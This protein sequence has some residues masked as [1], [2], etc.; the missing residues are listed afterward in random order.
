[1]S[2]QTNPIISFKNFSFQYRAQKKPTL[3]DINLDIYPGER[4]LIAGPSGS[5]KSTLAACINGLN[6]FSNP[7]EC[8]G[9]LTVDGVDAPNS[10]IF[11]LS[12][13]VGTVLQDPDGQFIG[14]TVGEDIAF[15]LE[16][17]CVPQKEMHEITRHAAELVGIENRL[18]HAPHELSGG[19]KQRVSL[20]GVMVD[21]VKILM[22]DEP[23]ASLDPATGKQAIELIDEIQHKTDTTVL[24]IEHRLED[25][26]WR[27]VDR[28]ILVNEGTILA[29]L[30]PDE[31][32]AP[33]MLAENGIREPL[34]VTALRYAGVD[35][36]PDKHPAHVDSLVLDDTDTQ[37]LRDWFTARPRPAAQPEREPLLEVKGLSF[38]YQKGQ[39][40]LRDVSFSIGKGEMVSIVGRNGAG[41][42]TLSKLICGF[43]TPDAGE[44]F[45]NGKPLAEENIRRRAQHIGYVMQN[46][47]Q[48]ISKTMIY[49]E[50]A[51][52]LQRSGLTE[53]QIREKVEATL[54]V[55]GLYPFR[56]WPISALSFGQKKRVTIASVLVLD[57]E[58]I[59]LDEPTAGQDF[60]HYTDIMEFL[61]GL[62]APINDLSRGCNAQEVYSMAIITAALA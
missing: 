50:V 3:H 16:N 58:L 47:N 56:N 35:I 17:S 34:Y 51:L 11:E 2:E 12:A 41:K 28:I 13:H 57:P 18:D 39:Q 4:V 37:K 22:F 43:E 48:M 52:G 9:S 20:A 40:T 30:R 49:E 19:Q 21:Q 32:L 36:T 27:N 31:L 23:L 15:A 44:I 29:A 59:L 1:M 33:H 55:C 46:P 62:N 61:L 6:P 45:L 7:G 25:V 42:S 38:G 60:R 26:L 14:L 24:I 10:S 53:E 8:T 5:G 54:R